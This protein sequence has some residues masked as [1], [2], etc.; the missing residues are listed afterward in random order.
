M[1]K[2]PENEILVYL[3]TAIVARIVS[4]QIHI[5]FQTIMDGLERRHL[6]VHPAPAECAYYLCGPPMMIGATRAMLE[7][8]GVPG[9]RIFF[10]D[11]GG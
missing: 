4:F 6:A 7:R 8:F 1:E 10:D 11:F 5:F 2:G 9:A 3:G